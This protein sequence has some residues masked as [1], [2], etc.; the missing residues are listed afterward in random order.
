MECHARFNDLTKSDFFVYKLARGQRNPLRDPRVITR[1]SGRA[2]WLWHLL[3][4][5]RGRKATST[6]EL[7]KVGCKALKAENGA[8]AQAENKCKAL[9]RETSAENADYQLNNGHR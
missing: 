8:R 6:V 2:L 7:S 9:R 1:R 4:G 5:G 3:V